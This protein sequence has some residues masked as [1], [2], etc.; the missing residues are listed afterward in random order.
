MAKALEM[1]KSSATGSFHLLL[2]IAGS[3]IIMAIGTL[4]LNGILPAEGVGLYG[5]AF[6]PSAIINYFRDWGINSALTK[7]I[8][9]LRVQGRDTEIHDVIVS[10]IIFEIIS[11]AVLAAVC[12]AIAWPLA[13]LISHKCFQSF[14]LHHPTA[15]SV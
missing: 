12:F 1:G 6:I 9:S 2:G 4:I 10:G 8:A 7:Q 15:W 11:G 3:T 5:M 14:R 13:F